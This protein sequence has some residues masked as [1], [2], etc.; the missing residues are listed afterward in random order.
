MARDP[1]TGRFPPGNGAG[2]GDGWGGPAKGAGGP[3]IGG[4]PAGDAIRAM[5]HDPEVKASAAERVETLK[6]H[7][8]HLA[9]NAQREETQ[10][11]ATVAFINRVE[12]TPIART[13]TATV[14]DP[15]SL[16]DAELAAIAAGG[17]ATTDAAPAHPKRPGRLVN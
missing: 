14:T 1:K 4:G 7:L 8:F 10:L 9:K 6:D 3:R 12:G 5:A 2:K 15:N 13:V 16:T 17:R 11:A